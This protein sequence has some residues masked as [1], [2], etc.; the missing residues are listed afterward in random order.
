MLGDLGILVG[1]F[2]PNSFEINTAANTAGD[3]AP[4]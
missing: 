1:S 3:K 2:T 4:V